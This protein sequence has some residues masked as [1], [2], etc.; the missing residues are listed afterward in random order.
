MGGIVLDPVTGR[1]ATDLEML[2]PEHIAESLR[3][4]RLFGDRGPKMMADSKISGL[5]AITSLAD[6]DELVVASGGSSNKITGANLKKSLPGFEIGYN[7]TTTGSITVTSTTEGTPTT[8]V[9]ASAYT[10]DGAA[11]LLHF[12][13]PRVSN[14]SSG[15]MV[16]DLYESGSSIG[17]LGFTPASVVE[18]LSFFYRFTPSAGSHTYTVSAW[19]A[20]AGNGAFIQGAAGANTE[21][22]MFVRF[23]KV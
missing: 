9:A 2:L 1:P 7:Q 12:F 5:A 8:L 19:G 10:F 14:P 20:S 4:S 21:V 22:P 17:R 3:L 15:G 18:G 23:T 11:V 13:C 16:V 6:T